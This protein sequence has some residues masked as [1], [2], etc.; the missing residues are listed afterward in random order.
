MEERCAITAPGINKISHEAYHADPCPDPS[1]SNGTI[2][3]LLS[4]PAKA[5]WNHPRLNPEYQTIDQDDAKFDQGK[6]AHALFLE[7]GKDVEVIGGFDNWKKNDAKELREV[8]RC[9]GKIPI[10]TKQFD[11]L[12]AMTESAREQMND[13]SDIPDGLNLETDGEAEMSCFWQEKNG[14]WCRTRPDWISHDRK[15]I[16]DYKTTGTSADPDEFSGHMHRMGYPV[17]SVFYR[18]G[19]KTLFS[20]V[21]EFIFIVQEDEPPY[22]CSFMGI[23]FQAEDMAQQ[24]VDWAIKLW[25]LCLA[26]GRWPGYPKRV[27]YA[28]PNPWDL[29]AWEVKKH[30]F[31]EES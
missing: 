10:L 7:G 5:W 14:V 27:C 13:C 20:D 15:L 25:R 11:E 28:E 31:S 22:L 18:R 6:A 30:Q 8:A 9:S 1:L 21:A 19:V 26:K 4:S 3:N 24:K 16:I 12:S 17:Q 2:I 29:A 23:D